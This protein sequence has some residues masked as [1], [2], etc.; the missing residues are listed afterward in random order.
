MPDTAYE[1]IG[2]VVLTGSSGSINF[3]NIDQKFTDL[4]MESNLRSTSAGT[5]DDIGIIFNNDMNGNY[6]RIYFSGLGSS[7]GAGNNPLL[8]MAIHTYPPA[9]GSTS[10][11]FNA[12]ITTIA[13]Y[14]NPNKYKTII[15]R[16]ATQ[17]A[18]VYYLNSWRNYAAINS[19]TIV[20]TTNTPLAAGSSIRLYG[21]EA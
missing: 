8:S 20:S 4:V 18:S 19:I 13:G 7:A 3:S 12:N 9:V 16:E 10:N 11:L 5:N 15:G 1:L 14:S 21:I 17:L 6:S 2:S